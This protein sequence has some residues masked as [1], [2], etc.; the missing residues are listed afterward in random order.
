MSQPASHKAVAALHTLPRVAAGLGAVTGDSIQI[1]AE[2]VKVPIPPPIVLDHVEPLPALTQDIA[3]RPVSGH[4]AVYLV[5]LHDV[6]LTGNRDLFTRDGLYLMDLFNQAGLHQRAPNLIDDGAGGWRRQPVADHP[7]YIEE[8]C[9]LLFFGPA[10]GNNH[11]H[12]LIQT[13]PQLRMYEQAGVRPQKLV[14]QPNFRAYQRDTLRLL[15]WGDN[16]IL[17][18]SPDQP[19]VFRE[20]YVGYVDGGLVPDDTVFGQLRAACPAKPGSPEKLYVSRADARDV[21]RFLN[22]DRLIDRVREL[23]FTVI[24]SGALG[25]A[26]AISLFQGARVICGPLGAGLYNALFTAPGATIIAVSDPHYVMSWLPQTATLRGHRYGW[27]FG[28]SFDSVEPAYRGTHNNW[29]CDVDR[30]VS[31]LS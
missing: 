27:M 31:Q 14:V 18:R 4:D 7:T 11:S 21:R 6:L 19:C 29:I 24:S 2:Q 16:D 8:S 5:K 26:E 9:G 30:V 10:S 15:G 25:A 12:W 22:E 17:V 1:L 3:T 20:L 13:L 28:L 23:G